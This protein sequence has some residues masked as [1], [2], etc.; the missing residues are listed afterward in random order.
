L[1][2]ANSPEHLKQSPLDT[3]L[4]DNAFFLDPR[5]AAIKFFDEV[6]ADPMRQ[7]NMDKRLNDL[8]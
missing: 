1:T 6:Q 3:F 5:A 8:N 7:A 2:H 4:S